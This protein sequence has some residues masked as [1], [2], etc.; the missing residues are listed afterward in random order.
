MKIL[1]KQERQKEVK[2][3]D[4]KVKRI[5]QNADVHYDVS[6]Q[7]EYIVE[8]KR[9]IVELDNYIHIFY[10]EVENGIYTPFIPI[11]E[12]NTILRALGKINDKLYSI[13]YSLE[14]EYKALILAQQW[15]ENNK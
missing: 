9:N 5:T 8:K 10:N 3:F 13:D 11:T 15:M 14:N 12:R 6:E 7:K 4:R 1:S 2:K